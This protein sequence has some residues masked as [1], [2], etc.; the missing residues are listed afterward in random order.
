[1]FGYKF[2]QAEPRLYVSYWW[3]ARD[4]SGGLFENPN[5]QLKGTWFRS[6]GHGSGFIVPQ[7]RKSS[8]PQGMW[9]SWNMQS[10]PDNNRTVAPRPPVTPRDLN[11][12]QWHLHEHLLDYGTG[13]GRTFLDGQLYIDFADLN[14]GNPGA[15]DWRSEPT[16]GGGPLP[17]PKQVLV[18]VQVNEIARW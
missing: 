8:T 14:Y 4:A 15:N 10:T 11:D 2:A 13:L 7:Y 9:P 18:R 5:T 12:G 6:V 17:A 16:Y 1:V 3:R